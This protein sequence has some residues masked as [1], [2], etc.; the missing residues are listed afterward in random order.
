[1]KITKQQ[2]Q[3]IFYDWAN[4][5]YGILVVTAVLPVYFKAVAGDAGVSAADSTAYWGYAN[6]FGTLLISLLAPLLGALADYPRAK[7]RLLNIFTWAGIALTFGLA[8]VSPPHWQ[9]LLAVYI[10]SVVGYSGGNLFYDSFL[11]DVA[12]NR[13]MDLVSTTGYGMG[14]L[15]GVIAFIIFLAAQLTNGF[16]GVLS[17]YG[18]ARFSFVI[19]AVWWIIFAWPLLRHGQQRFAVQSVDNPLLDSFRRLRSTFYHIRQYR[20]I[21]WFLIAYFFYID[22]VDTIFTMATSIGKD[23][24]VNTSMLM[25]VLLVVQL[26]AFPFSLFYGWLARH[27]NNRA[28]VLTGISMYLFICLYAIRLH[29][30]FDFWFLAIL[31]GTTQGGLQALSRSYFGQ[32][33]PKNSSSEFFGFYNILGKFSAIMGPVIVGAVT[34]WTG[35]STIGVASLAILFAVGLLI[36]LALPKITNEK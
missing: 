24:G 7:R 30:L 22:G 20:Q 10:L 12:D 17:A 18:V 6:S 19:A 35:K 26:I 21:T 9:L 34:Q 32:L 4:S 36:F 28:A 8:I 23:M 14:Y 31:I 11:T 27:T 2:W 13:Q 25:I 16:G 33:V 29:N 5:G 15:G 3:W 1:M